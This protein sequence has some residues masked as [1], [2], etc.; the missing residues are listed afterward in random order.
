MSNGVPR[1]AALGTSGPAAPRLA[2][3]RRD[4]FS[5]ES[6]ATLRAELQRQPEIRPEVV[7]RGRALAAD[8]AYPPL[9]VLTSV[10]RQ[11]LAAPDLSNDES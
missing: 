11:I 4:L 7:A 10:A 6:A 5:S 8:P 9:S 2:V 3:P 1:P